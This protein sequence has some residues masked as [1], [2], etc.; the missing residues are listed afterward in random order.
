MLHPDEAF[1]ADGDSGQGVPVMNDLDPFY[2][3]GL[4]AKTGGTPLTPMQR[5]KEAHHQ[6]NLT[7]ATIPLTLSGKELDKITPSDRD[8]ETDLVDVADDVK[9][10]S[11]EGK[12]AVGWGWFQEGFNGATPID[13]DDTGGHLDA[14]GNPSSYNTHHNGPQYFGYIANNPKMSAHMHGI[15]AFFSAVS[16][17]TLSPGGGLYYVKGGMQNSAGMKPFDRDPAVQSTFLGDDDHPGYSDSQI[18]EAMVAEAVNRIAAGKYWGQCA[19]VITWDDSEGAYDHVPPPMLAVGPDGSVISDGPRVPLLVI[20]PY[21]RAHTV[22][23]SVGDHASVVKLAD[24]L[25][26]LT[27]LADLPDEL[28]AR[29]IGEAKGLRNEGPFDDLTPDVTDLSTAFDPARLAGKAAPLPAAYA[30][31]PERLVH[32]LPQSI[33]YGWRQIGVMPTDYAIGLKN[34]VPDDF[35]PRPQ[36]DP[37]K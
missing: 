36:T 22:V 3:P 2:G 18:S 19:I 17:G 7:Y 35:N 8:P 12:S 34:D 30:E 5:A 9:A 33:G 21:A 14:D 31:I 11:S 24:L 6:L 27:P 28:R 26:G 32:I 20:S 23:H 15:K 25:F 13:E 29:K 10:I 16:D 4:P 37:G 1:T